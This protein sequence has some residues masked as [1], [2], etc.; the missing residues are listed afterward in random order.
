MLRGGSD[1]Q[2]AC[3]KTFRLGRGGGRGS[4]EDAN[5]DCRCGRDHELWCFCFHAL[6]SPLVRG[7]RSARATRPS[8][9]SHSPARVHSAVGSLLTVAATT[10]QRRVRLWLVTRVTD[11][12][13]YGPWGSKGP[14]RVLVWRERAIRPLAALAN[15]SGR[16]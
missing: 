7:D 16:R 2:P 12:S 13:F 15:E 14:R 1:S 8:P 9:F 11:D 5:M 6:F 4:R 3:L 10:A